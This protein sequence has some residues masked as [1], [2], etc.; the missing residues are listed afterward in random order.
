MGKVHQCGLVHKDVKPANILVD[1]TKTS[2]R[3]T[4][5]GFAS[6]RPRERQ[7]PASPESIAGTLAY[8]A[9]EQTGRMNRSIDSRS[10]LY[11]LG[12]TF[13]QVLTGSLPFTATDPMEWVHCHIAR[14]PAPPSQR[15]ENVPAAV[16][17]IIMNPGGGLSW[18]PRYSA[19]A[20]SLRVQALLPTLPMR[21]D[22][23][24]PSAGSPN[25]NGVLD[26]GERVLVEPTWENPTS[27]PLSPTGV[28]SNLTGPAGGTYAINDSAAGY[29]TLSVG[30][31]ISCFTATGNCY[32]MSVDNAIPRPA[33]H[34]DLSFDETLSN[35][36]VASATL[37]VGGSFGDV[38]PNSPFYRFVETL[39]HNQ[40]TSGCGGGSYCPTTTV[41]R[42]QMAVFLLKSKF[43]ASYLAPAP[44]GSVFAD[45]PAGSFGAAFIENLAA[46][47][48]TSGCGGGQLLPRRPDHPG[49]DVR[50]P[51]A[52]S[53]GSRV[54]SSRLYE[55]DLRRRPLRQRL[56]SLGRGARRPRHHRRLRRGL[57]CPN[58]PV[59]R[60]QMAVFLSTTFS[61]V[62]N[63]S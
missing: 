15:L 61:L 48:V 19:S 35:G 9:P 55:P 37:H 51:S 21:V 7:S 3:L 1:R 44:S 33:A 10:D 38:A 58:N 17:R 42:A 29:G 62:L 28:A 46:L 41:T 20:F 13:Y 39:F 43:G 45:V 47:S 24:A 30:Q 18:L 32:E 23:H 6:R 63:G 52:H 40:I 22:S 60:G 36:D 54:H 11:S 34:W 2:V 14:K 59:T 5:F 56:R 53:R 50:L 26:P 27:G 8:M 16:S 49:T 12:V 57:Y 4:G 25:L 31:E